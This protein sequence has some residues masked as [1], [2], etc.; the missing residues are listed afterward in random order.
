M[1]ARKNKLKQKNRVA[2]SKKNTI[3]LKAF[4][5]ITHK[6]GLASDQESVLLG[7]PLSTL[8]R[9]KNKKEGF[10]TPDNLER[11][12]YILGIYKALRILLPTEEAANKWIKKANTAPLFNGKSALDK[13]MQGRVVD[14]ADVRR[15]LDAERGW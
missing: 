11:I 2:S 13:F 8:Y 1:H 15:Y 12:S 5:N 3:A 6:W 10:L 14:L 9:W 7:V 4:F